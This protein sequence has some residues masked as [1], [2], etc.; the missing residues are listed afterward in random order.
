MTACAKYYDD[1]IFTNFTLVGSSSNNPVGL[2]Q[3]GGACTAI[4]GKMVGRIIKSDTNSS[5][6]GQWSYVQIAGRDQRKL[7]II[8]A[9]RPCK[10]NKL[11][12]STVTSQQKRLLQQQGIDHPKPHTAWTK[13]LCPIPQKWAQEGK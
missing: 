2:Y 10:Q 8:T 3:Q 5:G 4:T 7:M 12:D 9:Y 11:G 6:L 1:K 13:D